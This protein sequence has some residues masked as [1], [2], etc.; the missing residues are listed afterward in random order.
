VKELDNPIISTSLGESGKYG[1][2]TIL[3]SDITILN[4]LSDFFSGSLLKGGVDSKCTGE[5]L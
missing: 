4:S 2:A 5:M 3:I 1:F